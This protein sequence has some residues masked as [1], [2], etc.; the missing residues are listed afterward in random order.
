MKELIDKF[1]EVAALGSEGKSNI[2][3][4][5]VLCK[6]IPDIIYASKEFSELNREDLMNVLISNIIEIISQDN[7]INS[8]FGVSLIKEDKEEFVKIVEK[9]IR[10]GCK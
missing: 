5:V 6:L 1:F 7:F 2:G 9:I 8:D 10:N 4:M 3:I